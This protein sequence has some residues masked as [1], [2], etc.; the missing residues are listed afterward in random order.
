MRCVKLDLTGLAFAGGT[1]A[2]AKRH[3]RETQ[4]S[5]GN[6]KGIPALVDLY[7]ENYEF[8]GFSEIVWGV[9][10]RRGDRLSR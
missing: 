9:Y 8:P 7:V 1:S 6:G 3:E 10:L 4:S 2:P 5:S